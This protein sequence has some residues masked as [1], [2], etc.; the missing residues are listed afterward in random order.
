LGPQRSMQMCINFG[1]LHV[2]ISW[3]STIVGEKASLRGEVN[4][5]W[6]FLSSGQ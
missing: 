2:L 5:R 4:S 3:L 6:L 1:G